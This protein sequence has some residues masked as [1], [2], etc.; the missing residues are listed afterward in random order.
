MKSGFV[1]PSPLTLAFVRQ[2][3][4]PGKYYDQ[5]GL[6]L[7]VSAKG[8]K[9]WVQRLTVL[10]R[11]RDI[12]IGSALTLSPAMARK[13]AA[14]NKVVARSGRN[15]LEGSG[16]QTVTGRT[17]RIMTLAL[18]ALT[19]F[20]RQKA[21]GR[22]LTAAKNDYQ[23][24]KA[25][26]IPTLGDHAIADITV[27]D[28][29]TVLEPLFEE[30]VTRGENLRDVLVTLFDVAVS[31]K[32]RADN[33]ARSP[34][35]MP[36]EKRRRI[37]QEGDARDE[38]LFGLL[39]LFMRDL[40]ESAKRP[41]LLRMVRF[42]MLSLRNPKECRLA[43]WEQLDLDARI[44]RFPSMQ[45][46]GGRVVEVSLHDGLMEIIE[47][48]RYLRRGDG[49]GWLFPNATDYAKPYSM[50]ATQHVTN[51]FG[52]DL[53]MRDFVRVFEWRRAQMGAGYGGKEWWKDVCAYNS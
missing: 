12:G 45:I 33:P 53:T 34:D 50:H 9:R 11:R 6:I 42:T 38:R 31:E 41:T 25:K 49:T 10:G 14:K 48:M 46:D 4:A 26:V 27:A 13:I 15:P 35:A 47:E 43:S 29:R 2:V 5:D 44:W 22:K 36:L 8:S 52:Y 16:D 21:K 28:I 17:P 32:L 20:R 40:R 1:V 3:S 51:D 23:S 37:T 39:P 30:R 24:I 7:V 18:F 19:L